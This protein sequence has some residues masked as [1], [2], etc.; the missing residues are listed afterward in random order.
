MLVRIIVTAMLWFPMAA[1]KID[2]ETMCLAKNIFF[3]AGNQA[4]E[5]KMAVAWV[6]YNR[7]LHPKY[8]KTYCAVV[9]QKNQ[10][11]WTRNKKLKLVDDWRWHDSVFVA[12]HFKM[13][14]DPTKGSIYF[15]EISIKPPWT[16][17][18]KKIVR[19][20]NHVFYAS[21]KYQ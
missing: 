18:V 12:R 14:K 13:T 10:F 7:K 8:P 16:K 3:E 6:T 1:Q 9:Y 2:K 19:I 21:S 20:Q 4:L 15:H 5:G 11:S 17:K